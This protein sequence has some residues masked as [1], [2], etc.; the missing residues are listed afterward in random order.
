MPMVQLDSERWKGLS[1]SLRDVG[2]GTPT[3][4][5]AV[6]VLNS[7]L[8]QRFAILGGTGTFLASACRAKAGRLPGIASTSQAWRKMNHGLRLRTEEAARWA[9]RP[10][11]DTCKTFA[12]LGGSGS[13]HRAAARQTRRHHWNGRHPPSEA[14]QASCL[15]LR[16]APKRG[17]VRRGR[18]DCGGERPGAALHA[19]LAAL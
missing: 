3:A 11:V 5:V 7:A 19:G 15:D 9:I 17:P 16:A 2:G 1:H 6:P 18:G 12:R 13:T 14:S 8:E 10:R 4:M